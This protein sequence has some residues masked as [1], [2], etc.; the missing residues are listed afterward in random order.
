MVLCILSYKRAIKQVEQ[1][2]GCK[3]GCEPLSNI[4]EFKSSKP[5]IQEPRIGRANNIA[6]NPS[7]QDRP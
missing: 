5:P 2:C 6:N 1:G 4:K 7:H 3:G